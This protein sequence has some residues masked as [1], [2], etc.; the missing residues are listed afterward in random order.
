MVGKEKNV[1]QEFVAGKPAWTERRSRSPM[2]LILD[3]E[4]A[5]EGGL[6]C[7]SRNSIL[8]IE[9][10]GEGGLGFSGE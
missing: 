10:D 6:S 7:F 9:S 8:E 5:G 4:L 2:R 3:E 1:D